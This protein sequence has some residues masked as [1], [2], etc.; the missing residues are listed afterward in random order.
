[1]ETAA[2]GK[3]LTARTKYASS[4]IWQLRSSDSRGDEGEKLVEAPEDDEVD[5]ADAE[6]ED[7]EDASEGFCDGIG[8]VLGMPYAPLSNRNVERLC[9]FSGDPR[10]LGKNM[11]GE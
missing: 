3:K 8:R 7:A 11:G 4:P 10:I 2:V 6:E 9:A 1:M 5:A